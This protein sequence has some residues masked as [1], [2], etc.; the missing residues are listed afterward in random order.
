MFSMVVL[1]FI[2]ISKCICSK[3]RL[4]KAYCV[5][6][7]FAADLFH[8]LSLPVKG[9]WNYHVLEDDNKKKEKKIILVSLEYK[10]ALKL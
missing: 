5:S 9:K 1:H 8:P 3:S 2:L 6:K 10:G 7:V 4:I